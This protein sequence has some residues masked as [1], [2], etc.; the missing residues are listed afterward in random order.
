MGD[1]S[2]RRGT[3]GHGDGTVGLLH[4]QDIVDTVACH[5]DRSLS[6][7]EFGDDHRLLFRRDAS[8]D[9]ILIDK[10]SDLIDR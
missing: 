9:R 2:C 4:G 3:V 10:G 5:T 6:A 1:V 7:F 8:E